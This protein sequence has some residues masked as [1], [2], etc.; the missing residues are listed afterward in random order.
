MPAKFFKR[1]QN[2]VFYSEDH[3]EIHPG[4][5]I[6]PKDNLFALI[7][8]NQKILEVEVPGEAIFYWIATHYCLNL[9]LSKIFLKEKTRH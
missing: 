4:L 7:C 8:E 5:I 1:Y 6:V 3:V 2:N 9:E